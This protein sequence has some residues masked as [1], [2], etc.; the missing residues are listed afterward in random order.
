MYQRWKLH[1]LAGWA[2]LMA[3]HPR[4]VLVMVGLSVLGSIWVTLLGVNFPGIGK[5]GPLV[6]I[7][8]VTI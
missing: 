4:L 2:R 8:I 5:L 7:R 1:L 6:S 3:Q